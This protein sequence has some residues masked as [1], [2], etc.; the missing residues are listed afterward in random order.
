M[1]T[2][3]DFRSDAF[4]PYEGEESETNPR[5]HGKRLAEYL[6]HELKQVGFETSE[7]QAEDWGWL[8][9]IRNDAFRLW[10]GCGNYD[11][12]P[13][14]FLCFIEPHQRYIRRF[15]FP[16]R[17]DT[18]AVVGALQRAIDEVLAANPAVREKHWWTYEEFNRPNN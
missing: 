7:P 15:P 9:P 8:I 5:R 2:H 11:E 12:H 14:G 6:V 1:K 18:S 3:V 16:W 13:D 17:V 4:P 10:I